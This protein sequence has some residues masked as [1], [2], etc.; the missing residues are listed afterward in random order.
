LLNR[1]IYAI[2]YI[3][4]GQGTYLKKG[5]KLINVSKYGY[6]HKI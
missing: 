2:G 5:S 6:I 4:E 1:E 3:D